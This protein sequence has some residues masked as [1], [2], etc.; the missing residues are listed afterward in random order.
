MQVTETKAEGLKREFKIVVPADDIEQRV[1]SRLGEIAQTARLPGFRPG[2]VPVSLLRKRFGPSVMGEVLEQTVNDST[3]QTMTERKLRPV[4]QPKI[5][6]TAFDMGKDLEYTLAVELMPEIEPADLSKVELE[7]VVVEPEQ[8]QIDRAMESIAKAHGSNEPLAAPRPA[9]AGDVVVIDFVGRKDGEEFAGGKAENYELELGSGSFIPGFEEKLIGAKSGDEVKVDVTFPAE[10]GATD[11]AGKDVVF[12]V[13]VKDIRERKPATLDDE[14]AKKVGLENLAALEKAVR[15]DHER[16]F[17]G[18]SRMRLKRA[19]LDKLAEL[20]E[21]ETPQGLVDAEFDA[22]WKQIEEQREQAKQRGDQPA[23]DPEDA[24]KSDDEMKA[25]YR[26][27]AERRV[28]LGLLL[29]EIGRLNNVEVS[30]EDMNRAIAEE[31]RRHPGQEQQVFEYL[32]K[33]PQAAEQLR[34]PLY[35]DKVVDFIVEMAKVTDR[36][37]SLQDL[38][39]EEHDHDH[40][41]DHHGHDHD[42]DHGHHHDHDHDHDHDHH[43]HD[44]DHGAAAAAEEK[45]A[46]KPRAK[47][48]AKGKEKED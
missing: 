10:Y 36:K 47:A 25:E 14:L 37:V 9:Q 2:K 46:R 6:I 29:T 30:P 45:P 38:I 23:E 22:I 31:A 19:V 12:D 28:K 5:E 33:N 39:A 11:L 1:S 24:G 18:L 17:R 13:S 42:H 32:R 40:D 16:E 20:H 27:I 7:R 48:K 35:E 43:G 8:D 41:H 44:H 26:G 21:F 34:A 15:D 3:Q 4:M